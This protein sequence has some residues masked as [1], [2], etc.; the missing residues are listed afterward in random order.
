MGMPTS[1]ASKMYGTPPTSPRKT[2]TWPGNTMRSPG[3]PCAQ[4]T[5][6]AG[7]ACAPEFPPGSGNPPWT[8]TYAVR[9][10]QSNP[11]VEPQELSAPP[12]RAHPLFGPAPSPPPP[13]TY[14]MPR[15][16]NPAARPF[17]T[18]G[19]P[20]ATCR[21]R[22]GTATFGSFGMVT[23]GPFST[24][25]TVPAAAGAPA[26]G[27][28]QRP[29]SGAAGSGAITAVVGPLTG[30]AGWPAISASV[31]AVACASLPA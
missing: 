31:A 15:T 9:P 16:A 8:M 19:A 14:G 10:E 28:P 24:T 27:G 12:P 3:A 13:H 6:C 30:A 2:A 26:A 20:V 21:P 11:M 29:G 18:P 17:A 25:G 5:A 22:S 7:W 23:T 4:G 1:E